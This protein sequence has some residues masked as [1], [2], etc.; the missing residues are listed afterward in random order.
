MRRGKNSVSLSM[1]FG[2]W[3]E[4]PETIKVSPETPPGLRGIYKTIQ[5]R[6]HA[7]GI[8]RFFSRPVCLSLRVSN[9]S[10]HGGC[11]KQRGADQL[12]D[13]PTAVLAASWK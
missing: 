13:Q 12:H 1:L 6:H 2:E 5:M 4:L 10:H 7:K 11:T 9:P 3:T 8:P